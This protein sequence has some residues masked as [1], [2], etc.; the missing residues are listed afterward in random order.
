MT[1][2]THS[3]VTFRYQPLFTNKQTNSAGYKK[4]TVRPCVKH[5]CRAFSERLAARND[6]IERVVR[7]IELCN[8]TVSC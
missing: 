8:I 6:R 5:H 4:E 2:L 7:F 1:I 3:V